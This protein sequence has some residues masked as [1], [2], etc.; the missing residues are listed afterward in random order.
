[1]TIDSIGLIA[2][3]WKHKAM[4]VCNTCL[5]FGHP[6]RLHTHLLDLITYKY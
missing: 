3:Y 5:P 1:M 2:V 6:K 4:I